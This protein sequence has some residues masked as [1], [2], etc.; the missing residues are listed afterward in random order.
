MAPVMNYAGKDAGA[1]GLPGI[2]SGLVALDEVITWWRK[3][4]LTLIAGAPSM[5]CTALLLACL[6]AAR[7]RA[8]PAGRGVL[9]LA[10]A[11]R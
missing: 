9:F 8:L 3:S 11:R 1:E 2:P 4:S 5:G 7:Q 6:L 10:A